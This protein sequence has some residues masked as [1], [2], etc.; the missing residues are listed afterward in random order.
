MIRQ[1]I[2]IVAFIFCGKASFCQFTDSIHHHVTLG[3]TGIY[4]QTKDLKS[5]VLNNAA[6]FEI[7]E[8][9]LSFSAA[10]SW[11]YGKQQNELSNNDVSASANVDYL[12]DVQKLYYW[13][14][15]N[16]DKS[17]SL[18]INYRFQSGVGVGYTFVKTPHLNLQATDG[19][20]FE[21]SD[22][23]DAVLGKDIYQTVRNSLRLKY[24]WA[25]KNTFTLTGTDFIQ[26]SV[27][28]LD[29]YILKFTNQLS[30]KLY[31]WLALAATLDYNKISRTN[32]EN[33]LLTFGVTID[34]YF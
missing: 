2:F 8:K 19:F 5:F 14:L 21:T 13:G 12:K 4:N 25:Y 33:L 1:I 11:V 34:E 24:K 9:K 26:P 3:S 17:Y 10:G 23:T 7:N 22:L 32:R 30:V 16:Y 31:K 6:S 29:D 28:S 27:I 20:I 15:V 18:K